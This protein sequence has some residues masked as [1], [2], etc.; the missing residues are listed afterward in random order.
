ML[1]VQI[2]KNPD[3]LSCCALLRLLFIRRGSMGKYLALELYSNMED[4]CMVRTFS[5]FQNV[6]GPLIMFFLN[7]FLQPA[8]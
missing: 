2:R 4:F 8:F 6:N 1:Q 5:F 3:G 7:H